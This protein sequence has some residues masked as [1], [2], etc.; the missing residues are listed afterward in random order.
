MK[1]REFITLLSAAAV[2]WPLNTKAQGPAAPVIGFFSGGSPYEWAPFVAAFRKGLSEMGYLEGRNASVEFRWTFGDKEQVPVL[3]RDLVARQVDIIVTSGG[4]PPTQA[5]AEATSTIPIVAVFGDDPVRQKLIANLERPGGNL[6]GVSLVSRDIELKRLQL[7]REIVPR[8]SSVGLITDPTIPP[9]VEIR[10]DFEIA[11]KQ[12]GLQ[13]VVVP[14]STEAEIEDAFTKLLQ[15]RV[16]ALVVAST[17]YFLDRRDRFAALAARHKIPAIYPARPYVEAGGLVSYGIDRLETYRQV[18][19][20]T[21][22]ILRGSSLPAEM[23]VLQPTKFELVIN[24]KTA[25]AIGVTV[26]QSLLTLADAVI[27]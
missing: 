18:G 15:R 7:L 2:G 19:L 12:A 9:A 26:P 3:V 6:T 13:A 23:P 24:A 16:D 1:R 17:A 20:Y 8:A 4:I 22:R 27:Q 11:A 5:S 25:K 14:A 21:G 10:K